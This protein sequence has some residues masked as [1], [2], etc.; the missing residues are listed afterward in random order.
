[1]V[2]LPEKSEEGLPP[3]VPEKDGMC[4]HS[5]TCLSSPT[6]SGHD[7]THVEREVW[8]QSPHLGHRSP[9][10]HQRQSVLS[11]ISAGRWSASTQGRQR[12][13]RWVLGVSVGCLIGVIVLTG[14]LAGL[15]SRRRD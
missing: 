14:V 13:R 4:L 11:Y 2:L 6:K 10:H 5:P 7:D 1:M 12:R 8:L 15:L 9:D 3:P